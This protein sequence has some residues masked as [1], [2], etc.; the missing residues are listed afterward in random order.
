MVSRDKVQK[1]RFVSEVYRLVSGSP[2]SLQNDMRMKRNQVRE[3]SLSL[4]S[5]SLFSPP[6]TIFTGT[7][8]TEE[9][10][11]STRTR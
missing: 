5:L 10:Q 4:L 11:I 2:P 3:L 8:S 7:F 1:G 6:R 9:S